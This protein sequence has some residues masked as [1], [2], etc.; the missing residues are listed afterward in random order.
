MT[1]EDRALLKRDGSQTRI[2]DQTD[3]NTFLDLV[4]QHVGELLS[5]EHKQGHI[6]V[7]VC[8]VQLLC[9]LVEPVVGLF[10]VRREQHIHADVADLHRL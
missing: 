6:N 1:P 3:L 5:R 7:L 4:P 2:R 10:R 9:Q 8:G